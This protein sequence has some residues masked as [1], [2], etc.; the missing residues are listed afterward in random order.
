MSGVT[1]LR[2]R[3]VSRARRRAGGAALLGCAW[4]LTVA[5]LA[6]VSGPAGA[7]AAD[8][9]L[10]GS[11]GT[12]SQ[13]LCGLPAPGQLRCLAVRRTD[14]SQPAGLSGSSDV[15]A[16][17]ATPAG[18]GPAD[19]VSA[20]DLDTTGGSGQT[21][22]VVDAYDNPT[23]EAELAVYRSQYGLP[24][25]TTANGCFRKVNQAG[26][27]SP[28]PAANGGWAAEIALDVDMVSA[29]CP[30]CAILLVE[31]NSNYT[32]D[33]GAA[34]DTAVA[35]G[36]KFVS[37]SYGG[38]D[39]S[40]QAY[41]FDHPG[42]VI[43]ASTGD[44]GYGVSFPASAP[45]VTA[46]G[47]TRLIR[48]AT[49]RGWSESAWSG[50]GSGCSSVHAKPAIQNLVSTGCA[51]RAVADVSAVADPS[52]GVAVY[53]AGGWGVY[54]GTSAS[55]PIISAVYALAGAPGASDYPN[56]YPYQHSDSLNDVTT[57]TN[58]SCGATAL[59][60][61][62][63]GWDG[64]TG[65]GTPDGAAAFSA[66]GVVGPPTKLGATVSVDSPVVPGLSTA[67]SVTALLPPGDSVTSI[68]WKWA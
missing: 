16:P 26:A 25:C 65:L 32:S 19:L 45:T 42:V 29:V 47:G 23:A 55:S 31:A 8:Q 21:V 52:T 41:H 6:P 33:L 10:P 34:V 15:A 4:L 64:P 50:A 67:A 63:A 27:S 61:S 3:V 53:H 18:Y 24:A 39:S 20:Y 48:S 28:L 35:L 40:S 43:T 60:T 38:G 17:A 13:E 54:G 46:V 1:G 37:N 2:A 36:A 30:Q 11:T 51:T 62:R 56:T 5:G 58:G 68:A 14:A 57:G 44:N 49:S 7:L 12:S 22:A 66:T 59:C 9:S